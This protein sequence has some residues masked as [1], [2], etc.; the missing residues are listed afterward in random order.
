M[1][2]EKIGV[3]FWRTTSVAM[4]EAYRL[5]L[6]AAERLSKL[7]KWPTAALAFAVPFLGGTA[8]SVLAALLRGS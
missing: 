7:G 6:S 1:V 3:W 8:V 2:S 5:R 4:L